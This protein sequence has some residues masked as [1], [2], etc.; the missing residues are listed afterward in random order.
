MPKVY[1][2]FNE[3]CNQSKSLV[4]SEDP[5]VEL[6]SGPVGLIRDHSAQRHNAVGH[7]RDVLLLV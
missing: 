2:D 6:G 1:N 7:V 4:V 5:F 3:N